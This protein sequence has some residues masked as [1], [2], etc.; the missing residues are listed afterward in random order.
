MSTN[1]VPHNFS[2]SYMVLIMY[3][4]QLPN[5]KLYFDDSVYVGTPICISVYDCL[6]IYVCMLF[7]LFVPFDVCVFVFSFTAMKI[8][9]GIPSLSSMNHLAFPVSA[10]SLV[11][12]FNLPCLTHVHSK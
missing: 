10:Y 11:N 9:N 8:N 2:Y 4:N 5:N 6:C 1:F 12:Y 3:V 7:S